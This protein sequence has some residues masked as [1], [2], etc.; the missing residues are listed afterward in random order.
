MAQKSLVPGQPRERGLT[1]HFCITTYFPDY[2]VHTQKQG[3]CQHPCPPKAQQHTCSKVTLAHI[4]EAHRYLCAQVKTFTCSHR[5][6]HRYPERSMHT[7]QHT[8]T[9]LRATW[10]LML[11]CKKQRG[12]D[13]HW[14]WRLGSYKPPPLTNPNILP[15]RQPLQQ[16]ACLSK[17]WGGED[18]PQLVLCRPLRGLS[19]NGFPSPGNGQKRR[20]H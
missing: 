10:Q 9:Q 18:S 6:V 7:F 8:H 17:H 11:I 13:W 20:E 1:G 4:C 2:H 15:S 5:C 19:S 12:A 16:S 14:G 3:N